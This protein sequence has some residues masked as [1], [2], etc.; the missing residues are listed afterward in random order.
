M[1][2]IILFLLVFFNYTNNFA[3]EVIDLP[4]NY[5]VENTFSGD[6]IS[7][8][9]FHLVFTEN[10]DNN[11]FELFCYLFDGATVT[12]LGSAKS[13]DSYS[14][15]SFHHY[16]NSISLLVSYGKKKEKFIKRIDIDKVNKVI[17]ESESF[18]HDD[19]YLSIRKKHKTILLY[20]SKE[21]FT[22]KQFN[23][24][25]APKEYSFSIEKKS[26]LDKY[27][28]Y[29]NFKS[30]N[31]DEFVSNGPANNN[32]VYLY[33]N[34]L[35]FIKDIE[36]TNTVDVLSIDLSVD[37]PSLQFN[38]FT[39]GKEVLKRSTSYLFENNLYQ[40]SLEKEKGSLIISDVLSGEKL[41]HID[42]NTLTASVI[43]TSDGFENVQEF[44]KQSAKNKHI[45]TITVNK[46]LNNNYIVRFDYV[47]VAYSY[48]YDW[49][50]HHQQFMMWNHQQ[51]AINDAMKSIPRFGPNIND[52]YFETYLTDEKHYFELQL[53][54]S[55][56][57]ISGNVKEPP[58]H[59]EVDKKEYIDKLDE[60]PRLK[61][62][63]SCFLKDSFRYI[64][65]SN[66]QKAIVIQSNSL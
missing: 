17:T 48:N 41:N 45:P 23:T 52:I 10:K 38:E 37:K 36:N 27:L 8:E 14:I 40:L 6:L 9:S 24:T 15:I 51:R 56:S 20:K 16:D 29:Q 44:L 42:L 21:K 33:D 59:K 49:W 60:I 46:T 1:K 34:V 54:A 32:K 4:K 55:L 26:R 28:E 47:D 66:E 7:N 65:Y 62:T 35:V 58:I 19:F 18:N 39:T 3:N 53:D 25:E 61:H 43:H 2:S 50:W 11:Q 57:I 64:A 22:I 30:V 63:S 13:S 12:D 5:K 31:T